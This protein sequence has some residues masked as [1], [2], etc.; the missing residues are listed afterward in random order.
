MNNQALRQVICKSLWGA[1]DAWADR[2][3]YA[4]M[5][6]Q[7]IALLPADCLTSLNLAQDLLQEWEF[8]S[9][10]QL[11]YNIQCKYEESKLPISVPYVILKGTS[12]AMYYPR[13][14]YRAL[15]DIDVITSRKDFE[16]AL[17]EMKN[18]GYQVVK[19]LE[20]EISLKKDGIIVE[21]HRRFASLND[22]K[23]AEYLDDLIFKNIN[24]AHV[25]PDPVNGL[26][27]LE[28]IGQH[29]ENGLGLRQIIDWMMFVDKRLSDDEWP[30]FQEMA[31]HTGLEKLAIVCTQMCVRD[32]GLPARK[33]CAD[34]DES[35]CDQLMEYVLYSGNFGIK[36][37]T[38]SD[39]SM[40]V[41][42]YAS[43]PIAA[44]KL[45]QE[46]GLVNWKAARKH[47]WLRPF[48]WIYQ[49]GRYGVRGMN[50]DHA[51]IKFRE[52][53]AAAKRRTKLFDSLGIKMKAK[54]IVIYKDG[55]YVKE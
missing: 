1:G 53:Y 35:L 29:L 11:T 5:R 42:N 36:K 7:T 48:A 4:E 6:K 18:A 47:R 31:I 54:G 3:L 52:E 2:E 21:L 49:A 50:R 38:A 23:Q 26:V 32:L 15:G 22:V 25:L 39:I 45:F 12:A 55:K 28:H 51:F 40:N 43:T 30:A 17:R 34:A 13:P 16:T 41:L 14:D 8:Y 10:Q 37:T 20:R 19:E 27:L 46:R 33:W 9:I 24:P 44:F